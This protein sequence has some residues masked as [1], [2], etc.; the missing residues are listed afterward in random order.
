MPPHQRV[1]RSLHALWR[2]RPYLRPHMGQLVA[3]FVMACLS[4]AASIAVPLVTK[5]V[6]DGPVRHHEGGLLVVLGL[7]ALGLGISEA[8]LIF[9]RRWIQ[10]RSVLSMEK[11]LR[12]DMYAHLQR[13]P[14]GFHDQWQS[15]QLLS[16]ATS[17]L[18]AIRRFVAFGLIFFIV[19]IADFFVVVGLLIALYWPL[20][21]L[22]GVL[23]VPIGWVSL[24]FER[25]Y[26]GVS[27]RVQDQQGDLATYVE[28]AAVGIRVIK[29]FGRYRTAAERFGEHAERLAD[30]SV[31]KA[32]LL[33]HFWALL[34]VIPGVALALVLLLGASA[35]S[36]GHLTVGGLVAFISLM[37]LLAWPVEELGWILGTAQEAATAAERVMELFD[38]QPDIV[39]RPG[40]TP[41]APVRGEL[42][43]EQVAFAYPG[44][45]TPVLRGVDLTVEPGETIAI[46]GTTGCGKTTL[47]SLV[48]RLYDVTSGRILLD[49][50]DVRDVTLESLRRAVG[51]AFEEPTLFSSS[52][53]DNL[54][55]GVATASDDDIAEALEIA[56]AEFV[57]ELPWG[58]DTRVGEQ[59]LTLSG[60]QRQ[61][62]ALARAVLGRPPVLV[63]D[64][65]L[66]ALD[67][68][69]EALVESALRR[70]LASSTAL[71][72]AHR[73]STVLLADRVALLQDGAIAAVGTHHDLLETVP[74]YRAILSQESE[75]GAS[76]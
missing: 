51:V 58:L 2:L 8:A 37:Y 64:D 41:L 5:A 65:P 68:H 22:V 13:L 20:G 49:G 35:V 71:V 12:D 7:A 3:M 26:V 43:F 33:A 38:A 25:G 57:H 31:R 50:V 59:G 18:S 14:V 45:A 73:P 17:D 6:I 69:T 10:S 52:V 15:G 24:E 66:S 75:L 60:G 63:L 54:T 62:L 11:S 55:L 27:R 36:T 48:P 28:E 40:A 61:R 56:Q 76:R 21:V 44:S 34:E 74:A 53:R 67:V 46:V 72:V 32:R 4:V 39:D 9:G 47:I 19:T 16:R 42:R 70:V 1:R 29:A 23:A 30:T